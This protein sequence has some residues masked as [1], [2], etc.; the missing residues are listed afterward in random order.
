MLFYV[1]ELINLAQEKLRKE[2][3]AH[4]ESMACLILNDTSVNLNTVKSNFPSTSLPDNLQ[5]QSWHVYGMER[6]Q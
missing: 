1:V 5:L 6:Q 4:N 2:A 3:R